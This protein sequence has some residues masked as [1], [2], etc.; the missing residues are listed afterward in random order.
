LTM[1]MDLHWS[2][3]TILKTSLV[4]SNSIKKSTNAG[5]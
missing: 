5:N 1:S 3:I 2:N 4:K